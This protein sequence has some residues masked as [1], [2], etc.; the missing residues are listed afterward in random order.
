[1][2][3]KALHRSLAWY[4]AAAAKALSPLVPKIPRTYFLL[5]QEIKHRFRDR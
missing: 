2:K 4:F 1:M 5:H 3:D